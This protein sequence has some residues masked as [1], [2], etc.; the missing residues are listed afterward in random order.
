V[1]ACPLMALCGQLGGC[2]QNQLLTQSRLH[3]TQCPA[4]GN[5]VSN[6]FLNPELKN[7]PFSVM[8]G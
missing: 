5:K 6:G 8:D 7:T 1:I 4:M 3:N 2:W